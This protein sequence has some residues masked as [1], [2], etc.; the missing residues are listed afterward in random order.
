MA[1]HKANPAA[2]AAVRKSASRTNK[3]TIAE[4][5]P[6]IVP[7]AEEVQT[8]NRAKFR[9][10]PRLCREDATGSY[11]GLQVEGVGLTVTP[12]NAKVGIP[13]AYAVV[14]HL[15]GE[16]ADGALVLAQTTGTGK[17][18]LV[19]STSSDHKFGC[20]YE[21][22]N[23]E[24]TEDVTAIGPVV[25]IHTVTGTGLSSE[26]PGEVDVISTQA[27]ANCIGLALQMDER[28]RA[29]ESETVASNMSEIGSNP[30]FVRIRRDFEEDYAKASGGEDRSYAVRFLCAQMFRAGQLSGVRGSWN[31]KGDHELESEAKWKSGRVA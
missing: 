31:I 10:V 22:L 17:L 19:R 18:V 7:A 29:Q 28:E 4:P 14:V 20:G 13:S 1:T 3:S 5:I 9:L 27:A 16:A 25:S 12:L 23:G 15:T 11:V 2:P 26:L 21:E 6:T 8:W 24:G 30:L